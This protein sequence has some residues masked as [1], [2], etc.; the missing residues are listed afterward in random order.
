MFEAKEIITQ[1]NDWITLVFITIL[2]VL[3]IVK[4]VF[5]ERL[6]HTYTF[7]FYKK[8]LS[9]YFTKEKTNVFNLFQLLLFIVQVLT[10][11]LFFYVFSNYFQLNL[12]VSNLNSFLIITIVTSCYFILRF[13][14]GYFL[15][16]IFDV[17]KMHKIIVYQKLNYFNNLILWILPFV[18]VLL[19]TPDYQ[20]LIFKITLVIFILLLI[21]RYSLLLVNNKKLI[22]RNLLYFI[23]YLCALEIAPLVLVL[24]LTI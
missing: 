10:I 11:S 14:I 24:K 15:A 8:Y 19:Y 2:I 17:V 13:S 21:I 23:L 9:I 7:F 12:G 1:N 18:A 4:V 5:K 20:A 6:P 22:F 16:T 3:A